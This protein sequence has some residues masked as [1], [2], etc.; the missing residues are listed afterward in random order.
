ML[1]DPQM[2]ILCVMTARD[3][4]GPVEGQDADAASAADPWHE[5]VQR[6]SNAR[7]HKRVLLILGAAAVAVSLIVGYLATTG[8]VSQKT[9]TEAPPSWSPSAQHRARDAGPDARVA[10]SGDAR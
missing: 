10:P 4:D 6:E 3:S 9:S 8:Y 2:A 1:A 5:R 7:S